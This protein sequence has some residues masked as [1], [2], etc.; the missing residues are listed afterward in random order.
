[1]YIYIH[2]YIHLYM[3]TSFH[4]N[5]ETSFYAGL[6]NAIRSVFK[7]P[8]VFLRLRPWQFEI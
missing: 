6:G 4:R 2:K 7:M 1:M 3:Y 5:E 8:C